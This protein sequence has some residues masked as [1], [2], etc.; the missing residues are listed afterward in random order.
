MANPL[1]LGACGWLALMNVSATTPANAW[2][3][4]PPSATR[5]PPTA[6]S[7]TAKTQTQNKT[8]TGWTNPV[9]RKDGSEMKKDTTAKLAE[10]ETKMRRWHT[11]L[12]RATN[13]LGKLE[14]QRRRLLLQQQLG[15]GRP[16][17]AK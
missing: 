9:G 16:V 11:R 6:D 5:K 12:T 10:V 3:C 14:R 1:S 15:V 2:R 7:E 17:K 4:K 13:T 8:P